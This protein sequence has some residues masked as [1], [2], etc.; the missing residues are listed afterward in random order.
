[1]NAIDV[2]VL[3]IGTRCASHRMFGS[4]CQVDPFFVQGSWV[5]S[6]AALALRHFIKFCLHAITKADR[7]SPS[8]FSELTANAVDLIS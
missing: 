3:G 2:V 6:W 5:E 4:R 7:V 1:M 8:T